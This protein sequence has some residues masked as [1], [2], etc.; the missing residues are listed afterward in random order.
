MT[1][2]YYPDCRAA[3]DSGRFILEAR[4][5]HNGTI[6]HRDGRPASEDEFAF[7]YREHQSEFRYRLFDDS[8]GTG[9]P[10][11]IWE[12]FQ[13]RGENSPSELLVS[14]GWS[15]IRTHGFAPEIIAV[16]PDGRDALRVRIIGA[17]DEFV[18]GEDCGSPGA[19]WALAHLQGTTAGHFWS[20]HSWRGFFRAGGETCFS[21][22]AWWGQRLVLDLGRD[23][24]FADGRGLPA[25]LAA[26]AI[27]A[28]KEGV[29]ALL[30][31]LSRQMGDV[32]AFLDA[33]RGTEGDDRGQPLREQL[34]QASAAL[35]LVGAHRMRDCIPF[36][37]EWE[38]PDCPSRMTIS[39]AMPGGW[40][41]GEQHYRPIVHHALKLLGEEPQGFPAYDFIAGDFASPVRF[42]MPDRIPDRRL[43]AAGLRAKM[44]AEDVLGLLGSPDFI[45]HRS[46]Q[47]GGRHEA[48]EDWEYDFRAGATWT[49]LRITWG[50]GRRRRRP[51]VI[52]EVVPYWL[53]SHERMAESL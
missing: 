1:A 40:S 4:S 19:A 30:R 31:G 25:G 36:L 47:A 14:E 17:D 29:E 34:R 6:N 32:C 12:R 24:V 7:Q 16:G 37:R 35:H 21:W 2:I 15:V 33:P 39:M 48:L 51:E 18:E 22:R 10:R 20:S 45:R 44:S 26:S 27:E 9:E 43:W 13:H 8:A 3:S 42:P 49:T 41:L 50:A 11:V 52:E 53:D 5:P 38:A 23:A 46:R 28:E